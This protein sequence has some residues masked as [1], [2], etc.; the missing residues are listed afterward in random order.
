LSLSDNTDWYQW[1][2]INWQLT[3]AQN[4][5][6]IHVGSIAMIIWAYD[7]LS[8]NT[9]VNTVDSGVYARLTLRYKRHSVSQFLPIL[10]RYLRQSF[11]NS[12]TIQHYT[13]LIMWCSHL[14]WVPCLSL[15]WVV[16][17]RVSALVLGSRRDVVLIVMIDWPLVLASN[18]PCFPRVC[19]CNSHVYVNFCTYL[20]LSVSYLCVVILGV[21]IFCLPRAC[22]HAARPWTCC[23][24]VRPI[25]SVIVIKTA[26]STNINVIKSTLFTNICGIIIKIETHSFLEA[27]FISKPKP[28]QP[29]GEFLTKTVSTAA[30]LT[31]KNILD[32]SVSWETKVFS[33]KL[34]GSVH[35]R[36]SLLH[37]WLGPDPETVRPPRSTPMKSMRFSN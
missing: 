24:I 31:L 9:N 30:C 19:T 23:L 14:L 15:S 33:R 35:R 29:I 25:I 8:M 7:R 1:H 21:L 32:V 22:S 27:H 13:K 11:Y 10:A 36:T 16:M 28:M 20:R 12:H 26:T 6:E 3:V 37:D 18:F 34:G 17:C 5:R 4:L 2:D